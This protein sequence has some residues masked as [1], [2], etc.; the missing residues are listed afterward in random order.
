MNN[1]ISS[2]K[3]TITRDLEENPSLLLNTVIKGIYSHI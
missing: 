2:A 3:L 1:V